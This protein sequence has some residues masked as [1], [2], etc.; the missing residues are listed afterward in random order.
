[1]TAVK[2]PQTLEYRGGQLNAA[3]VLEHVNIEILK[4]NKNLRTELKELKA[5]TETW[6]NNSNKVNQSDDTKVTIP[7]G[8]RPWLFEAEGFILPNHDTGRILPS[9]SQRNIIDSLAAV[10]DS[11]AIDYDSADESSVAPFFLH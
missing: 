11:S 3:P 10:T 8:E 7:G 4:E 1:M 6:L 5:I 2:V 9:E